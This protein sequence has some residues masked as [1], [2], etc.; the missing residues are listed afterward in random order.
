[1]DAQ[2]SGLTSQVECACFL[3]MVRLTDFLARRRC[4]YPRPI[5]TLPDLL[6]IDV[7]VRFAHPSLSLGR[8]YAIMVETAAEQEEID[9]FLAADRDSLV[10]PSL[11]DRRPSALTTARITIV[12]Y[13]PP[14]PTWPWVLLCHWPRSYASL[15][16]A[17]ADLFARGAYTV[18][19]FEAARSLADAEAMLLATL[20]QNTSLSVTTIKSGDMA[21]G[22]R[23]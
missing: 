2:K 17:E 12:E 18:E 15:V 4:L 1:L 8:Y 9:G 3:E 6:V 23:A 21:A 16:P 13:A 19:M 10:P 22:G 5:A 20:G 11:L 14:A 7:P